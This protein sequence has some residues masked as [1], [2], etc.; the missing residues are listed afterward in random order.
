MKAKRNAVDK[1]NT[2]LFGKDLRITEGDRY[3]EEREFDYTSYL[4][5]EEYIRPQKPPRG[6]AYS[7]T[8]FGAKP[9]D[10]TFDNAEAINR[11][12]DECSKNGGGIVA[13]SGGSFTSRTVYLK[14]NVTLFI[15]KDS[16]IIAHESGEGFSDMALIFAKDAE[17]IEITGSGTINGNGHL[18]GRKPLYDKNITEPDDVIDVIEMR[19]RYRAQLRFAHPSKYGRLCVLEN[20]KGIKIH[21]IIFK[22]SPSWTLRLTKCRNVEIYDTVINDNRH[23]CNTDGIDLMQTSSVK[24]SHCFI[25]CADDGIVLKNAIWE[26]CDGP[27]SDI[28]VS[29][30][31]VISCTNAFKIGTETTYPIKNVT[32]ENSKFYMTDLYP[33][34]VSGISL[35]SADGSEV[36]DVVCRNIEMNR[37]TC[38]VF[39][40]LCNRN[41]AAVVNSQSAS[42]IEFAAKPQ[43]KG[44][45]KKSFDMKGKLENIL[46]ENI[47]AEG[48]E[49]PVIIAGTRTKGKTLKVKNVTFNNISIKYRQAKDVIDRRMFIPEYPKVYPECWRFRNLPSYA[50][51]ARHCDGLT[52]KNF[53]CE[54]V[55]NTVRKDFIFDDVKNIE[56]KFEK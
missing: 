43:G 7:V 21:N 52:I 30:C 46:I 6:K 25:S 50:I 3:E 36:S 20:C 4:P 23:V 44:M 37:C 5:L 16:S 48:A 24:I 31:E 29:D 19:R 28:H 14:S 2:L 15:E 1:L 18:F 41:R 49:L 13:V 56:I 40:R 45:D 11:C 39:I 17:N 51:W 55:K 12:I 8:D 34:S 38:P 32:V 10:P 33:G 22:D 42:A 9:D 35:E 26:G 53:L 27:M 54:P 47:S